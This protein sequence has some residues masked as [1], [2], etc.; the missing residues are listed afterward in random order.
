MEKSK[1]IEQLE[2]LLEMQNALDENIM[3]ERE[4][5]KYPESNMK[6]ALLV[7]LGE[8]LNEFPTKFKHWKAS[9]VDNREKGLVEM[10][11]VLHFTLSLYNHGT[12]VLLEKAYN[13][14][15]YEEFKILNIDDLFVYLNLINDCL[16]ADE[17]ADLLITVFALSNHL[18]FTWDEI[19]QAYKDKNE[20][21]YQRLK[22]GY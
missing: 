7:E 13:K 4:L 20:I 9:A 1:M 6:V 3:K 2:E 5:T 12:Y 14:N 17:T 21:N 15:I 10:V 11:D 19:Y 22:N 16:A 18:G 8:L